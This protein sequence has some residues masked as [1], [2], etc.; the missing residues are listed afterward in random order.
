MR[1]TGGRAA[2]IVPDGVLF[3][4]SGAGSLNGTIGPNGTL[5]A[6]GTGS[7]SASGRSFKV[8]IG[9]FT[10][11]TDGTRLTATWGEFF[12]QA[13]TSVLAGSADVRLATGIVSRTP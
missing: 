6:S 4:S 5:K 2:V 3:G 7:Y 12:T 13:G 8:S 1:D 11:T 10:A 9:G